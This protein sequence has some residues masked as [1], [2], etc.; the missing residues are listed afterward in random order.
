MTNRI[1]KAR[2]I[3][4]AAKFKAINLGLVNREI[5]AQC[6]NCGYCQKVVID[7]GE[8]KTI[9]CKYCGTTYNVKMMMGV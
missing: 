3:E 8:T 4:H 7:N 1:A 9:I 6:N 2:S 5:K